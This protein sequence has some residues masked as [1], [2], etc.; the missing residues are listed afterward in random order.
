V[1]GVAALMLRQSDPL[2]R[3]A[4]VLLASDAVVAESVAP[5]T[6]DRNLV[7]FLHRVNAVAVAETVPA[8]S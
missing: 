7:S 6:V 2:H 1:L 5:A 4:E 8:F 3:W